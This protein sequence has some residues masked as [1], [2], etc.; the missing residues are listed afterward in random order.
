MLKNVIAC[1]SIYK[2]MTKEH[3]LEYIKIYYSKP[4]L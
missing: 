4:I 2:N 1:F 3:A